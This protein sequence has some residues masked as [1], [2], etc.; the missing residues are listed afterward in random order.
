MAIR[1]EFLQSFERALVPV[2]LLDRY[3]VAGV[4][5]SWWNEALYDL[6]TLTAQGFEGL[7]DGWIATLRAAAEEA[8]NS[9]RDGDLADHKLVQKLLPN[10]LQEIAE[11]EAER[12]E[13]DGQLEA[14]KPTDDEEG[15][16]GDGDADQLS[17]AETKALKRKLTAAKKRIKQMQAELIERLDQTRADLDADQVRELV[18]EVHCDDLTAQLRR[19]VAAQRQKVVGAVENSWDKYRVTMQ[20]IERDRE[21]A[22]QQLADFAARIGYSF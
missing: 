16:N 2:G 21:S 9:A 12:A 10:Y 5:A 8:G 14:A 20:D 6:K 11:V 19:Y 13:I 22:S 1:S 7:I 3:K 15:D 4:I 17:P 18:L